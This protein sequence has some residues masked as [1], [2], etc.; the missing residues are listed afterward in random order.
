MPAASANK[1]V[2]VLVDLLP[3]TAY[4]RAVITGA[5]R[6]CLEHPHVRL[7]LPSSEWELIGSHQAIDGVIGIVNQN[8][9]AERLLRYGGPVVNVSSVT[10]PVPFPT[11]AIDSC[12]LGRMAAD[13]LLSQGYQHMACHLESKVYY[14][15]E[16]SRGFCQ[17]LTESN[18]TCHT[19]DT[20]DPTDDPDGLRGATR[21]WLESLPKPLGVFTHNDTRAAMLL[22]ICL[23]AHLAVP[24]QVGVIGADDDDLIA[25]TTFPSLTSID[26]AG[27]TIGY[28]ATELVVRLI[29]GQPPPA[30]AEL[31]RPRGVV[32]RQS[33]QPAFLDDELLGRAMAFIHA[34]ALE[35][36]G[37]DA[38]LE[39]VPV[40]RR[41]L[42]RRFRQRVGRSPGEE[43]RRVQI[44]QAKH[45][46]AETNQTL[47]RVAAACGY[48]QFR[49]FATAFTRVT[50]ASPS[51]YRA[52]FRTR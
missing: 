44:E 2:Y 39:V 1:P 12:A 35:P 50:G 5:A 14:S 10:S 17:R 37:I 11:V 30:E 32:P 29:G 26:V 46:L 3:Q 49:N 43:I 22:D 38:V 36:I 16:R 19:F 41:S 13:H 40:S 45:L 18:R 42:E 23:D 9:P 28:R 27:D 48:S 25:A 52:T 8:N 31:V 51:Q 15:R 4:W 20:N 7:R 47:A 34:H 21:A 6:Y 33:T 24:E